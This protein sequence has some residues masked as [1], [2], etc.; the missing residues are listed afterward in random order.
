MTLSK[1][2]VLLLLILVQ[3]AHARTL[4]LFGGGDRPSEAVA[5]FMNSTGLSQPKILVITWAT[6]SPESSLDSISKDLKKH[7]NP[8]ILAAHSPPHTEAEKKAFLHSLNEAH[9]VFF[10]GGDQNRIM[11]VLSDLELMSALRDRYKQGVSFAGTSAGMAIMSPEMMTGGQ[12]P[13]RAGLGLLEGTFVD[14]HF[15]QRGREMR[16]RAALARYPQF[17]GIGVDE[18]TALV[19]S[20]E[21]YAQVMGPRPV[22]VLDPTHSSTI[23]KET[24]QPGE[25][26]DLKKRSRATCL[27]T[28]L[29]E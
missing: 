5:R 3:S 26:F 27:A 19:T 17:L 4:V 8:I 2:L 7:A 18:D 12:E 6:G 20:E 22:I 16:L 1:A 25:C 9:G 24:L 14:S 15:I 28:A 11:D 10:S 23:K 29:R 21:T 13:Y